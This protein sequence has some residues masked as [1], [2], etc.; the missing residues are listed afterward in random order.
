MRSNRALETMH[1]IKR[2][3]EQNRANK[4]ADGTGSYK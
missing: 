3:Q 2:R 4:F 1:E